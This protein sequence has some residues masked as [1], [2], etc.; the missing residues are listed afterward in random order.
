MSA[1]TYTIIENAKEEAGVY[2]VF[3]LVDQPIFRVKGRSG[4]TE[5]WQLENRYNIKPEGSFSLLIK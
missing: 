4:I 1:V 3:W 2:S 5:Q